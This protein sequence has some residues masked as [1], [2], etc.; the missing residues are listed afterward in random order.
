MATMTVNA[1]H[2]DLDTVYRSPYE[3]R[4]P[5]GRPNILDELKTQP[6][7]QAPKKPSSRGPGRPRRDVPLTPEELAERRRRYDGIVLKPE[8]ARFYQQGYY[9]RPEVNQH[10]A[11][12]TRKKD[13]QSVTL[14]YRNDIKYYLFDSMQLFYF[15][16]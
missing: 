6:K 4:R 14:G 12:Y 5:R 15:N 13:Q 10:T 9:Q 2:T 3:I 8:Y 7:T 1:T 11:E 16:F